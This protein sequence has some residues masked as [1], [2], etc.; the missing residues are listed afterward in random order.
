MG[1]SSGR[2]ISMSIGEIS[3]DEI[4]SVV[5]SRCDASGMSS[6]LSSYLSLPLML[7]NQM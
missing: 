5:G 2:R 3:D 1:S 7:V 6:S 4:D